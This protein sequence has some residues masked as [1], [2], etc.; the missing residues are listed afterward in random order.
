MYDWAHSAYSTLLITIVVGYL[1]S[2]VLPGAPGQLA[3][4]WG[5]GISTFVAAVLSP[6]IGA[7]ADQRH[8]K[9]IWLA[10]AALGG[11]T[12]SLL[13]ALLPPEQPWIIV[14]AFFLANLCFELGWSVSNGFLPEISDEKNIDNISA[15]GF[16]FGYIGGG[17]ALA[18]SLGIVM[19]G[20]RLGL[21]AG[22]DG[23]PTRLRFALG[24]MGAWWGFFALPAIL[25][26]RDRGVPQGP[27][28]PFAETARSAIGQ[29]IHTLLN[30]RRFP[31]LF[32][33]LIG[34]LL[35]NDGVQTVINS[36]SIF[37]LDQL[38]M[39][40]GELAQVVLMI[41]FLA[42]PGTFLVSGLSKKLGQMPTL[43]IC[44]ALWV[45]LLVAAF[46]VTTPL[47]FWMM[48]AVLAMIMGG[49][50]SVSRAI[51]GLMTPES[52]S[53]E[54]FGFFN[55]SGR[56]TSM[57]GP[58]LFTTITAMTGSAHW[59]IISLLVFFIAGWAFV[60]PVNVWRGQQQAKDYEAQRSHTG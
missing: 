57:L 3:Y 50:Q 11:A 29:V 5:I 13:M 20:D 58:P 59:G 2:V 48:A 45:M 36:A 34:F 37:A 33:F 24:L 14:V 4:G 42:M 47:Q 7:I 52:H 12:M 43:M 44:L 51:M 10:I 22:E 31:M 39:G 40:V 8:N 41:Q 15:I 46:F 27:P 21:P 25:F 35:F 38:K 17:I 60:L 9:R 16:S 56:A 23:L 19:I 6:I 54:F 28:K 26:L 32:L 53:A 1:T 18:I 30:V 55:F 49:T